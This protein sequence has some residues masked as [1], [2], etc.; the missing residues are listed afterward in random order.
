MGCGHTKAM[1]NKNRVHVI[2]AKST[3]MGDQMDTKSNDTKGQFAPMF[4]NS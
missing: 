1:R 4:P 2:A 3:D